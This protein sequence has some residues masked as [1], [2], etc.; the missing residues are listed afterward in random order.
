MFLNYLMIIQLLILLIVFFS[1]NAQGLEIKESSSGLP[2]ISYKNA[3][4]FGYG[5]SPQ[6]ILTYLPAG[7][8]NDY[9][10][11]LDWA[12]KY[13]M[14][15]VRSYPP[16]FIVDAPATN[17]FQQATDNSNK[18]D[19]TRFNDE[20]FDELRHACQLMKD[21]GFF[22]HFQLWQA[23]SWKKQWA[24]NYYNPENNI[25][26]KI[27]KHAGPGE[28]MAISNPALLEH[29]ID[30]VNKILDTIAGLGNVYFDIANEIGNGTD[31][32]KQWVLKILDTIRQWEKEN[33][34][35]VL[36][37]INDE[38]GMRITGIE[39]IFDRSDLIIKDLGR[40]DEH[41]DARKK[42][43]KPTVSVRNIDWDYATKHR[44]YFFGN[45]NLE[46][47]DDDD[48]QIRGRKYWWRMYMAKVQMAGA[49]ADSYDTSKTSTGRQFI[50]RILNKLGAGYRQSET[51]APSYSLNT[52]TEDNFVNFKNFISEVKDFSSLHA[53]NDIVEGH[54][55]AHNYSLQSAR[56]I[57]I[58]LE[59][60][61]GRSGYTYPA[62]Q[63]Q[64]TRL[65][66]DDGRY[67]GYFYRP[68]SGIK[69]EFT[70][71]IANNMATL[72][73][74]AFDDDLAIYIH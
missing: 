58:Y 47:N 68:A 20:Y 66:L 33:N 3:P 1:C 52:L 74:P 22:I 37:T 43:N 24:R 32:D 54:S 67:N 65:L 29:Q 35:K 45:D 63:V 60:P 19:L 55:A 70:T 49:Y 26:P 53:A 42:Y 64:L 73:V 7:N 27:S 40:W 34:Q 18:F 11:W 5:A 46:I 41:I 61:N 44:Q 14:N 15:N 57:V 62:T 38:G 28:F 50:N 25:N 69:M 72:T 10:K 71:T 51:M 23:V 8:G 21:K 2:Y 30:Y 56:E 39:E 59:S 48:L 16:S 12:H 6:N 9:K 36:V 13:Q 31:S 17:I 4:A